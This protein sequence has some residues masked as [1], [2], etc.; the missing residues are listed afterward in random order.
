MPPSYALRLYLSRHGDLVHLR[1]PLYT[2]QET[3]LRRSG[4]K[5][6]DYVN[7]AAREVQ[8]EMERACTSHLKAVGAWLAPDEY[9]DVPL[10][11]EDQALLPNSRLCLFRLRKLKLPVNCLVK[12]Y[13]FLLSLL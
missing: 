8:I 2:E 10:R 7:P 4:E 13:R 1:E 9:D 6:F 5:Q 3:D 12:K 11:E